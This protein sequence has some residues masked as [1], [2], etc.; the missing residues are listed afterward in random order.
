[1]IKQENLSK[2]Q[3]ISKGNFK[4]SRQMSGDRIF[5]DI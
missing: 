5:F 3:T 2:S 1:M 4:A